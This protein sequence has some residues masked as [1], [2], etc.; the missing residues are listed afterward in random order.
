MF[1]WGMWFTCDVLLQH[2][3]LWYV[4]IVGCFITKYS[5]GVCGYCGCVITTCSTGVCGYVGSSVTTCSCM[6]NFPV[7]VQLHESEW[8]V[9]FF[10]KQ[11]WANRNLCNLKDTL[12]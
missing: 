3:Q 12:M 10:N 1:N 2:V 7:K 9:A 5:T 6:I 4:I 8:D 11:K